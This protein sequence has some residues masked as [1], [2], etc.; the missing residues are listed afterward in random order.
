M[1]ISKELKEIYSMINRFEFLSDRGIHI[2]THSNYPPPYIWGFSINGT[3]YLGIPNKFEFE[4]EVIDKSLKEALI[5]L[6]NK[7]KNKLSKIL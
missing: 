1:E 4:D 6:S 7:R 3:Y 2:Y 5:L